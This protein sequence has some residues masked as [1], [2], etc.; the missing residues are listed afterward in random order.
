MNLLLS[1]ITLLWASISWS[2][3]PSFAFDPDGYDQSTGLLIVQVTATSDKDGVISSYEHQVT[4]NLFIYDPST[5]KGRKLFDKYYGQITAYILE[6]SLTKDGEIEYLGTSSGLAKNN[7]Q[8]KTRPIRSSI[9]IETFNSTTKQHTVWKAGKLTGV[10]MVIFS[11]KKPSSWHIDSKSG[12]I[13]LIAQDNENVE[14]KEY[15]W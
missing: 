7:Q 2:S 1:F 15:A 12:I 13:R 6:S 4:K 9:L 10:P 5:K 11:Y 3:E 8:I 14:V